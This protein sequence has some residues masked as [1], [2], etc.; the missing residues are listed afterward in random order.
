MFQ[1]LRQGSTPLGQRSVCVSVEN[2]VDAGDRMA[3]GQRLR[4]FALLR[5]QHRERLWCKYVV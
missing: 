5:I 3:R 1:P 4:E 2:L